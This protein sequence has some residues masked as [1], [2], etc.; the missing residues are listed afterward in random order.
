[1]AAVPP[2]WQCHSCGSGPHLLANIIRCPD[3]CHDLCGLCATNTNIPPPLSS[4]AYSS[5][6]RGL[7]SARLNVGSTL[8]TALPGHSSHLQSH[9]DIHGAAT[10]SAHQ[11]NYDMS[12]SHVS[13]NGYRTRCATV[14]GTDVPL[15]VSPSMVGWWKC[16]NCKGLNNPA[17][18]NG[19]CGIC[20]HRGPCDCCKKY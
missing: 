5:P 17:L 9:A 1:M 12:R 8:P 16:G 14:T 13:S 20:G 10:N 4:S 3:C 7:H 11:D 19:Q 15:E 2:S 6:S 18:I